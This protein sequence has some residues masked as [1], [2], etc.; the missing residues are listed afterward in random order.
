M[1][2]KLRI[3][4]LRHALTKSLYCVEKGIS[5]FIVSGF[6]SKLQ[7]RKR[8]ISDFIILMILTILEGKDA[9]YIGELEMSLKNMDATAGHWLFAFDSVTDGLADRSNTKC[10]LSFYGQAIM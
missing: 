3:Y 9:G 8:E 4:K 7:R 6:I 10:L 2:L 5:A 1:K